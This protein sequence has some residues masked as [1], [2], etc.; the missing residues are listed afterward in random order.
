MDSQKIKAFKQ[1]PRPIASPLTRLTEKMVMFQWSD[2]FEKSFIKL[3]TRL[4]RTPVSSLLEGSD[5]Y[6]IYCEASKVVLGCV[7]MLR[8]KVITYSSRQLKVHE[9]NYPT[10]DLEPAALVFALKIWKHYLY[11][12]HVNVFIDHKSLQYVFT[13]KELNLRQKT[14]LEFL[15]DYDISV[16]YH[17]VRRM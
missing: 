4:T 10:H 5:G 7:L 9:K 2:D 15:K 17:L 14:C 12:V 8:V 6:V 16:H 3:K 11:G 13:K 1:W